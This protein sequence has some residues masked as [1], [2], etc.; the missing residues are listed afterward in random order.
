[1]I[2]GIVKDIPHSHIAWV[3]PVVPLMHPREYLNAFEIYFNLCVEQKQYDSL[4][5]AN[6]LKEYFWDDKKV[7]NYQADKN[8]T[9]SQN[10][11]NIFRVTNGLYMRDKEK[12]LKEKYFLGKNPYKFC[13]SK[14]SGIDIDDYEDYEIAKALLSLYD[15]DK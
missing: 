6:L 3:V 4:F 11:A 12:I 5:S 1:M 7:L 2:C 10:L 8:H 14:I 9:I 15:K 13:V